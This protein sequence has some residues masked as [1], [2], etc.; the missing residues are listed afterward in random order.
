M[1]V[2]VA[3]I[4]AIVT[5]ATDKR[6]QKAAAVLISAL[7]MPIII[8]IL[9]IC[10][11]VSGTESANKSLLDYSFKGTSISEGFTEEQQEAI[12]DMRNNLEELDSEISDSEYSLDADMVKAVFYCLNFGGSI[13][14]DF[15]YELFCKCFDELTVLQLDEALENIGEE[16]P[17]YEITE[18][19]K[20]A[21]EKV[22]EYLKQ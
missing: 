22:Y 1:A 4:K 7:L 15:D 12:E 11:L 5:A 2:P 14:E 20:V 17:Q 16:F 21:A 19:V 6:A 13:D 8:L 9:L 10:S 18:N 3:V